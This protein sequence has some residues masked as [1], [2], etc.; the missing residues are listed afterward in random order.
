MRIGEDHIRQEIEK[1]LDELEIRGASKEKLME[2]LD[3]EKPGDE[4]LLKGLEQV[5]FG[6]QA[7]QK[8]SQM[9]SRIG[10]L[11]LSVHVAGMVNGG[12][13]AVPLMTRFKRSHP[14]MCVRLIRAL[15]AVGG[16]SMIF[17]L[18]ETIWSDG[19]GGGDSISDLLGPE[20][21]AALLAEAYFR[22]GRSSRL[23]NLIQIG[24]KN[25]ATLLAARSQWK[26][27]RTDAQ[28]ALAAVYLYA[29]GEKK[30][31][32]FQKLLG[33]EDRESGQMKEILNSSIRRALE[34]MMAKS[35][36][37][38]QRQELERYLEKGNVDEPLSKSLEAA[39]SSMQSFP[40]SALQA[41]VCTL[42]AR[43]YTPVGERFLT[44]C[45]HLAPW[46]VLA[47][48]WWSLPQKRLEEQVLWLAA[49]L[50][51]EKFLLSKQ[52]GLGNGE[53][54]WLSLLRQLNRT[55]T[56][57]FAK[58]VSQ[59]MMGG[60]REIQDL[61]RKAVPSVARAA[62]DQGI[63]LKRNK[64]AQ[65][66]AACFPDSNLQRLAKNYLLTGENLDQ[67]AAQAGGIKNGYG[68]DR[69]LSN[70]IS[71]YGEDDFVLRCLAVCVLADQGYRIS[72]LWFPWNGNRKEQMRH[73]LELEEKAGLS[74]AW[75]LRGADLAWGALYSQRDKNQCMDETVAYLVSR[76]ER[77]G[78]ELP[79]I[80]AQ[81]SVFARYAAISAM[82]AFGQEYKET[83]LSCAGDGAKQVKELLAAVYAGH[84]EWEEEI[85]S[86]LASKKSA[87][88]EMALEVISKWDVSRFQ[89]DLKQLLEKEKSQKVAAR[90]RG[91]L[92]LEAGLNGGKGE[93]EGSGGVPGTAE[94]LAAS[95][96]KGGKKR[97]VQW[98]FDTAFLPVKKKDGSQASEELLAALLVGSQEC[99]K[100]NPAQALALLKDE[101]EPRSL[102]AFACQVW[103]RWMEQGAPAKQKWILSFASAFGG[104]EA[105]SRMKHQI[106]Q[107]P[108]N[109]R[110]AIAC[111][112][113]YAL[114][115]SP[116]P[117]ALLIVDS[118]SRKFKFKQVKAAAGKALLEAAKKLNLT[119]EE[120]ADRIV[121][122]LGFGE[123]MS[124][125]FD[126]GP[127]RFTVYLSPS[128]ELE[129]QDQNGK[130]LKSLPAPG[131]NDDPEKAQEASARFKSLKKQMKAVVSTQKLR[132]EQALSINR[133]WQVSDWEKL[134]V[135]NP[136]MHQFA[137]SL[138]W[139]IY[140]E[141]QLLETFRY[142]EDGSFNTMDE[143]EYELPSEGTIGLVHPIELKEEELSAWKQQ[144]EDYEVEQS[145][146][147]LKRPVF[148]V[149]PEEKGQKRMERFGGRMVM[150]L[151]LFG[152]LQSMG[153]YRGSVQDGGGFYEFY[154]EDGKISVNLTFS[155][156]F[157]SGEGEMVTV[158]DA[159]FYRTGT[160]RR[161]SYVYDRPKDEDTLS[162]DEVNPRYFSEIV[163]Q[164][165]KAT[166]SS[167]EMNYNWK[168]E[169]F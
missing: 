26:G 47:G 17:A 131:K 83:L 125:T 82:D 165:Q 72:Q 7:D 128:L 34:E 92:G 120:L 150:D 81:G 124:Q 44:L 123:D 98:L 51:V 119:P 89:E 52:A 104:R 50:S 79:P 87:Q 141:D 27:Q 63:E 117:E 140:Q 15:Y 122:D 107:W 61:L 163:Y 164:L 136:V 134:F 133:K 160:V 154:R 105:V 3:P 70:Y 55:R 146:E 103:D 108:Q 53:E 19:K 148:S 106:S 126:Y 78:K 40:Y 161:G 90:C 147:Q 76:H 143:E 137:I 22:Q 6:K 151:S 102:E 168:N 62:A 99:S 75:L 2:Y 109:A 13:A 77:I 11:P 129:I 80:A 127:R 21:E 16:P 37:P 58:G 144:L 8:R 132:L 20:A 157:V 69:E 169:Q 135:K 28:A 84:P 31:G 35:C 73:F 25:P 64:T 4:S 149:T 91:L 9:A 60:N 68:Y 152:K 114:A 100:E 112:A 115:L 155:G 85:R 43:E 153:W 162:L 130:K 121:P 18:Q 158:Y 88:R 36:T 166:A 113:V 57:E 46:S 12:Q 1:T 49:H 74:A 95:L 116:E 42:L 30:R 59:A 23:R 38:G 29:A 110:G 39:L 145:I 156:S 167:T 65:T 48:A 71:L 94:E 86:L 97:R 159:V 96:L 32:L 66:L 10:Q 24:E 139:G 118:I 14:Q 138:I 93:P 56:A 5:D 45:L 142:M 111:D 54:L 67:L 33:G 41:A 101:L